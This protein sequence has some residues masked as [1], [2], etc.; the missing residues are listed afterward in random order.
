MP[1]TPIEVPYNGRLKPLEDVL[2]RVKRPGDFF[3]M[4]ALDAPMPRIQIEGVGVLS[5][6]VPRAQ[7]RALIAQ[8]ERAPFGRGPETIL[9][10]SVRKVWQLE[11]K[12]EIGGRSWARTFDEILTT[13][14]AQLGCADANVTAHFYK[15]LVYD[16]GAFFKAHRDTEKIDRMFG[17]LLIVLPSPHAGGDLVV[18]H[19]G[20]AVTLNLCGTEV[21]ELTYAA[22]YAD[23]EHE[24]LPVTAGN[25]ICLV[26]NLLQGSPR[27]GRAQ[28]MLAAP[29]Y[30][31]E[32]VAAANLLAHAFGNPNAPAK[33]VWLLEHQYSSAGLLFATL[34]NADAALASVLRV[35]TVRADCALHLGLVHIE[36]FGMAQYLG[37][38]PYGD[39]GWR[40]SRDDSEEDD[41]DE[42][43]S[44][45]DFEVIEVVDG[46][47]YVDHWVNPQDAH[48]DFGA[49]PLGD[50]EVLPARA[51]DGEAPDAQ[52]LME[53]SGNEGA[54]FERAYHRAVLVMWPRDR[55]VDVLLQAGVGAALPYLEARVA[56][57][58]ERVDSAHPAVLAEVRQ[59]VAAWERNVAKAAQDAQDYAQDAYDEEA[60]DDEEGYEQERRD[61]DRYVE[62]DDRE[63]ISLILDNRR[64][65]DRGRMVALLD[66]L[67]DVALLERF[68]GGVV[69][70]QFDGTEA[71]ALI[72]A[73]T[74]LGAKRCGELF[75][76]LVQLNMQRTP[77]GC[78]GFWIRLVRERQAP[79]RSD[80]AAALRDIGGAVV[81]AL[82][83]LGRSA[84]RREHHDARHANRATRIDAEALA[85]LLEGLS[86]LEL[87]RLRGAACAAVMADAATF[88]T[89]AVIAPALRKVHERGISAIADNAVRRLWVHAATVLLARSD[90]PP[91]TPQDWRQPV[92]LSCKC[93]DC[94]ELA[95]FA[96]EPQQHTHRFRVR[97][98]RR[99]H[100]HR[101]IDGRKLDMTHVTE[102]KGS[103][104][105]LV[106]VKT[107]WSYERRCEAYRQDVAALVDLAD[108]ALERPAIVAACCARIEAAR[109]RAAAARLPS[110][111]H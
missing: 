103:P 58:G 87:T 108:I 21:S 38:D 55:F 24:V 16:A 18:R 42:A 78:A 97:K 11:R 63:D 71:V 51:L 94:R 64:A 14:A 56:S 7:V 44:S 105:T 89:R 86:T 46:D 79:L 95:A 60:H 99:Q 100:L 30:G 81:E 53:A 37:D 35:A 66:R 98:D 62:E 50:G 4:G 27:K 39:S 48:V 93:D 67:G 90:H 72:A 47:S 45:N 106:C 68:V 36:E 5:F 83:G 73:A 74:L 61:Q 52:R 26:Y 96:A 65:A 57:P 41:E 2:A 107:R 69:T 40:D 1:N 17:T 54:S 88:D 33:I 9:D 104:Q 76:R 70:A 13:V 15:L 109:K 10:T 31:A 82:L 20:R 28:T 3:A 77:R 43:A 22:F 85:D 59:V 29:D 32:T 101:Q 6:P 92:N 110:V 75:S 80:W 23:C 8:C 102:R 84:A 111:T 19:A 12:V 91:P 34:K 25:R 49:L